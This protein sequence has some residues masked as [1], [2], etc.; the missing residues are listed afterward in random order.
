MRKCRL[1]AALMAG[2]FSITPLSQ[3][4]S[5]ERITIAV[6]GDWPYDSN[7]L[8]HASL[9]VD[10]INSDAAV[11]RVIFV[12]DI[13][14]G[15]T[16]CSGVGLNPKPADADSGW[17]KKIYDIFATFSSSVIYTPGDNEWADCHKTNQ[18]ATGSPLNELT[19]IRSLFFAKPGRTLGKNDMPVVTQATGFDPRYPADSQ[20]VENVMWEEAGIIFVTLNMPGSNNAT[21]PWL[22][23][24]ENADAQAKEIND[25]NEANFHWLDA[26]FDRAQSSEAAAVVIALHADMWESEDGVGAYTF[27]IQRLASRALKFSKP[28]LLLNGDS[29]LFKKDRPLAD[30]ASADG[31]IHHT[32]AVPNLMRISVQGSTNSPAEWL[33]LTIDPSASEIFQA[34]NIV[35][36]KR[37]DS[38]SCD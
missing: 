4:R 2:L 19:G 3:A 33:R 25:R 26:A 12:G 18:K 6:F 14:S 9:L 34:E 31:L 1:I 10:S 17:N 20:F 5:A 8:D 27:F 7:L 24:F 15:T 22:N 38:A 29:H 21:G 35:Y 28:V 23:G 16:P 32:P 37:T 36:C 13:H 11:R 30:P